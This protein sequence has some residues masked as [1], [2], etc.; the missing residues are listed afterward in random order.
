MRGSKTIRMNSITS[1]LPRAGGIHSLI[2]WLKTLIQSSVGSLQIKCL[3]LAET[4][5]KERNEHRKKSNTQVHIIS[6]HRFNTGI[7]FF[8]L[9]R[10]GQLHSIGFDTKNWS[11]CQMHA[12]TH[13]HTHTHRHTLTE[14]STFGSFLYA[15]LSFHRSYNSSKLNYFGFT[16]RIRSSAIITGLHRTLLIL[17]KLEYLVFHTKF[18]AFV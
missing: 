11:T 2:F 7:P 8:I 13:T 14:I 9:C 10:S 17:T 4:R 15:L 18:L 1:K 6:E 5:Q 3:A 12:H 16:A